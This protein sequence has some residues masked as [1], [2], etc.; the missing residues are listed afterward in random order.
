MPMISGASTSLYLL[1]TNEGTDYAPLNGKVELLEVELVSPDGDSTGYGALGS[2]LKTTGKGNNE[3]WTT[4]YK[5]AMSN[6]QF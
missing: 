5:L 2:Q 4:A 1:R 6:I 3:R